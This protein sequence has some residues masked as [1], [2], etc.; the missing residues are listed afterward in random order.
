MRRVTRWSECLIAMLM[1]AGMLVSC[2][3]RKGAAKTAP[4][5][6]ANIAEIPTG[7]GQSVF[8]TMNDVPV[9]ANLYRKGQAFQVQIP[10][11]FNIMVKDGVQNLHS[12]DLALADP[13]GKHLLHL[14]PNAKLIAANQSVTIEQGLVRLQFRKL[15][16]EYRINIPGAAL[17][18]RGTTFD[19]LVRPDQSSAVT[20]HEGRIAILQNGTSTDLEEGGIAEFGPQGANLKVRVPPSVPQKTVHPDSKN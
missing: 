19:V 14:K 18:V 6:K 2:D 4:P 10:E 9:K 15:D 5:K 7:E 8:L 11:K 16:G 12:Q 17:A 3:N 20:L 1:I 13:A